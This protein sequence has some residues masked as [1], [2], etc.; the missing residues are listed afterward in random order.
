M[1]FDRIVFLNRYKTVDDEFLEHSE[2]IRKLRTPS[3][4]GIASVL[5]IPFGI[6]IITPYVVM[7]VSGPSAL[8]SLLIAF[9]IMIPSGLHMNE[10][11]CS[12]PKSCLLYNFTYVSF[13][14]IPAFLVGWISSLDFIICIVIVAKNWSRHMNL[15]FHGLFDKHFTVEMPYHFDS[16]FTTKIDFLAVLAIFIASIILCCSIR[17]L[18]VVSIIM[19]TICALATNSTAFVG[20]Y[21]ADPNNWLAAGFFKDGITGVMKGASNYLC[22]YIGIETFSFLLEETKNPRKRLPFTMS[23]IITVLTLI[24]FLTT[25]VITLVADIST[26]PNDMLFPDIFDKL[27]IPSAKY[28]MAIGSVCGLSGTMLAIFVPATRILASLS[29]DNLLPSSLLAHTSKKRGVP[30]YAVLL[31]ALISSSLIILNTAKLFG[32]IAFSTPLRLIILACLV[33]NQRYNSNVGLFRETAFYRNIHPKQYKMQ[34]LNIGTDDRNSS[35]FTV[36]RLSTDDESSEMISSHEILRNIIIQQQAQCD[37]WLEEI[38]LINENLEL[39]SNVE[40]VD[41]RINKR[42]LAKRSLT[43]TQ[44]S[45][46]SHSLAENLKEIT[47]KFRNDQKRLSLPS[48]HNYRCNHNCIRSPCSSPYFN[49]TTNTKKHKFHIFEHDI[50]EIP[51]CNKYPESIF[52]SE[53]SDRTNYKHSMRILPFF[54]IIS[55]IIGFLILKTESGLTKQYSIPPMLLACIALGCLVINTA[56]QTVNPLS[57]ERSCKTPAFPYLTLFTIFLATLIASTTDHITI[58]GFIA[59]IV[60]GIIL[61]ALYGYRHSKEGRVQSNGL[62]IMNSMIKDSS[63]TGIISSTSSHQSIGIML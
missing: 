1:T 22:A 36:S 39:I 4:I 24:M 52:S 49:A 14:E 20:F 38:P 56:R 16:I 8:L 51:Y 30:Y 37:Q 11:M 54:I 61:Y 6:F 10:L 58:V 57:N 12:M 55:V 28:V 42:I 35:S 18:A 15:L 33:Y 7:N 25:M 13:G 26:Y 32:I 17:V 34:P 47:T 48:F 43:D 53:D 5:T 46:F 59:W 29:G 2:W 63:S 45:T 27:R 44:Y 62:I 3:L 60:I 40:E 23:F 9:I 31:C 21:L 41:G 19:V 50:P